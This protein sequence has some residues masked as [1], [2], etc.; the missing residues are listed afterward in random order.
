MSDALLAGVSGL[1]AHQTMLDVA[2]NNLANADTY[3]FKASRVTF[4]ELLS[5]TLR[6]ATQPSSKT[7]GTNP[8][9][10]GAGVNVASVD[11]NMSQ[12]NLVYTGQPLDMAIEGSGYFTLNDG[13][14]EVYTRVGAFAVDSSFYLVDPATG[15]R[16]QRTGSEGVAEGFQTST[17]SDIRIPYDVA[18]PAKATQSINF[19][20]NLS[21]DTDNPTTNILSSGI[22]YT[23]DEA[24]ATGNTLLSDLDQAQ[25]VAAGETIQIE[26]VDPIGQAVDTTFTIAAGS[27]VSDLLDAITAA[28]SQGGT[29]PGA[30]ATISNGE[31]RLTDNETGY[32]QTDLYLTYAG[33]H[34]FELPSYFKCLQVGGEDARNTNVQVFDSQGIGHVLSV[35]FAK[36]KDANTWDAVITSVTGT[37]GMDS[38]GRRVKGMTFGKDGSFGGLGGATPDQAVFTVNFGAQGSG[39]QDIALNLGTIGGFNGLSQFGGTSTVAANGQDGYQAG[40]L[41]SISVSREGLFV[42]MFTNGVRRD[43]AA[44]QLTTFQNPAGLQ[45]EGSNYFTVSANSGDPVATKGLAGGAGSVNG[46]SLEKSNVDMASEFVSLIQAQNGYQANARTITVT[47]AMLRELANLI[48]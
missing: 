19:A 13:Q 1:Q 48:R 33:T 41:S 22:S 2:G 25:G 28:F 9:Q 11:R 37:A 10:I 12:G 36:C 14:R 35:T 42:G 47:T 34:T 8:E 31:I 30:K 24:A 45:S 29:N 39:A 7:G 27:T 21:A 3:G 16:V 15:Y 17:S 38:D 6:E 46:G 44:L 26:G 20:G 43:I 40:Y 5:D 4:S 23:Q 32:S 18:L